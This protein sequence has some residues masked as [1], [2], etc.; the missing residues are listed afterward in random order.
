[1]D[2][3]IF[4]EFGSSSPTVPTSEYFNRVIGMIEDIVVAPDFQQLQHGFMEKYYARFDHTTEEN[5][6]EYMDIFA[7]YTHT[8]ES[9]IVAAL[10]TQ[11]EDGF[12]MD[13]FATELRFAQIT[14]T[15]AKLVVFGC[16]P[17]IILPF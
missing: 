15:K 4:A 6:I 9:F 5:R 3:D 11:M 12:D 1:M 13:R 7:D 10:Q 14:I 2:D 8:M 17:V 16:E